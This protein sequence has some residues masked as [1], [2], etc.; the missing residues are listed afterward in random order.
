[1]RFCLLLLTLFVCQSALAAEQ[2]VVGKIESIDQR[3]IAIDGKTLLVSPRT[4]VTF[5]GTT[6]KLDSK[7]VNQ[8]ATVVYD[9]GLDVALS[10]RI[11]E[12]QDWSEVTKN[13]QGKWVCVGG[14]VNGQEMPRSTVR[15]SGRTL[16]FERHQMSMSFRNVKLG[17]DA[18]H[19]GLY[20]VNPDSQGFDFIGRG[21]ASKRYHL[22]GL[23]ELSEDELTVCWRREDDEKVQRPKVIHSDKHTPIYRFV[24]DED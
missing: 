11:G 9:A 14:I 24:R 8:E 3:T 21:P 17:F 5:D 2:T 12:I 19:E 13:L 20:D 23:F 6:V 15:E 1:M 18:K 16:V 4:R 7:L 10:V 22:V